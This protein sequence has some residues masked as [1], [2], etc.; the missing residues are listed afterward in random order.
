MSQ[1]T[2]K[3]N[4]IVDISLMNGLLE[5]ITRTPEEIQHEKTIAEKYLRTKEHHAYLLDEERRKQT[6]DQSTSVAVTLDSTRVFV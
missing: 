1:E 5:A 4:L 3:L 2:Q 6:V